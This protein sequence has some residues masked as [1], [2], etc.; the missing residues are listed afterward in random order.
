MI[1]PVAADPRYDLTMGLDPA[2]VPRVQE[3]RRLIGNLMKHH[4]AAYLI[5][6]TTRLIWRFRSETLVQ[7]VRE[8]FPGPESKDIGRL[9]VARHDGDRS[10]PIRL[11]AVTES[12]VHNAVE[13]A[14]E[15][16]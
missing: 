12:H 2:R 15:L 3:A 7:P 10:Q 13:G 6:H 14:K 1:D 11:L 4:L 8:Y 9:I 16:F 5:R